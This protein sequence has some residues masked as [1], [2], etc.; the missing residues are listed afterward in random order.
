MEKH[1]YSMDPKRRTPILQTVKNLQRDHITGREKKTKQVQK[2]I[3]HFCLL[4]LN[5]SPPPFFL[6]FCSFFF[7]S[8][9]VYGCVSYWASNSTNVLYNLISLNFKYIQRYN[10]ITYNKITNPIF[11]ASTIFGLS[12]RFQ[13]WQITLVYSHIKKPAK[14]GLATCLRPR[15]R[16]EKILFNQFTRV[17]KRSEDPIRETTH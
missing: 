3:D 13:P 7:S 12:R 6:F 14:R 5:S 4:F 1:I 8:L 9:C 2:H 15:G 10:S 16:K 17:T 11:F